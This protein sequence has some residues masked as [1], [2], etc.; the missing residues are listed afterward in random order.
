MQR[1]K[2]ANKEP[3]YKAQDLLIDSDSGS[4]EELRKTE[5]QQVIR[6]L[7]QGNP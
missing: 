1:K 4:D 6:I 5:E 3:Q 2:A 7:E